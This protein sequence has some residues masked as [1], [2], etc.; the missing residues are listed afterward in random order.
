MIISGGYNVY[1]RE[2]EEVLYLHPAIVEC[3]VIGY[4]DSTWGEGVHALI[5]SKPSEHLDAE[6]VTAHCARYLAGYKKPR[7]VT[8]LDALP[9]T[10]NGKIDKKVLRSKYGTSSFASADPASLA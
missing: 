3:A 10:A 5:V 8:L 7:R 2:V 9:K 4:P 1:P 6:A